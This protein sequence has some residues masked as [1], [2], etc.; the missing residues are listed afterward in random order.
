MW[1]LII[2][3]WLH[4]LLGIFWFGSVLYLDF[5]VIPAVRKRHSS[6]GGLGEACTN[7]MCPF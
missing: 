3:Q 7:A 1:G 4:V 2:I 6:K 5:V